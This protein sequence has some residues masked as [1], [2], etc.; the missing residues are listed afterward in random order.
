MELIARRSE[1]DFR[2]IPCHKEANK[3]GR[4]KALGVGGRGFR[5]NDTEQNLSEGRE[6]AKQR[7]PVG[8]DP[9]RPHTGR[10]GR[11]EPEKGERRGRSQSTR[12]EA[13]VRSRGL[14]R[15]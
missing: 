4:E 6:G 8:V 1:C 14:R 9:G 11:E 5:E 3:Q 10:D 13:L 2:K 15:G 7:P 12:L